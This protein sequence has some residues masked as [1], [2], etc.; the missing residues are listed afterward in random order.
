[1]NHAPVVTSTSATSDAGA[2]TTANSHSASFLVLRRNNIQLAAVANNH[3]TAVPA[4]ARV[5]KWANSCRAKNAMVPNHTTF[6]TAHHS[7]VLT[8]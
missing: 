4:I 8:G 7:S 3:A 6:M 5:S 1:M 2:V